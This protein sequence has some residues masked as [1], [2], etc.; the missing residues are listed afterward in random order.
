MDK[1]RSALRTDTDNTVNKENKSRSI[2]GTSLS[3]TITRID[4][5][6]EIEIDNLYVRAGS[7]SSVT[8]EQQRI[9]TRTKE[10]KLF[11]N[12]MLIIWQNFQ[13]MLKK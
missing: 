11:W 3:N 10:R 9:P 1:L 4:K 2:S 7:L 13:L 12:A 6:S 5:T 8:T